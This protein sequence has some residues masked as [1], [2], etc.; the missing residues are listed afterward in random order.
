MRFL[1]IFS[2]WA[3]VGWDGVGPF[4]HAAEDFVPPTAQ[5][6]IAAIGD[7]KGIAESER[8]AF[9]DM[10]DFRAVRRPQS[11]DWLSVHRERGQTYQDFLD[12]PALPRPGA[13]WTKLYLQPIDAF[14][15]SVDL[16]ALREYCARFFAAEV[17]LL[18]AIGNGS[19]RAASRVNEYT[20]AIQLKTTDIIDYLDRERPDDG[21]AVIGVTM[22]DLYPDETW[23]FVFGQANYR[24]GV[25]VFSF[26]RYG[27]PDTEAQ[28]VLERGAK[29]MAHELGHM[30]GLL[31]CIYFDCL[32]NG[33]NSLPEMDAAP[34]ALC[35]VCLRKLQSSRGFEVLP[36]YVRLK[37]FYDERGM[38]AAAA[39][40]KR[41]VQLLLELPDL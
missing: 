33:A 39:F 32:M 41:R 7:P 11:D 17:T 18:P 16:E 13:G 5:R 4:S 3:L 24:R 21:F 15:A 35:P 38:R 23:N 40:T 22:T 6:R 1:S 2:L 26:A 20:F 19:I 29:V 12:D 25:G 10:T 14:P 30:H 34:H 31:H 9:F 27:N 36:R 8:K 37:S 28:L